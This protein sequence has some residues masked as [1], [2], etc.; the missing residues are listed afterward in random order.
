[1]DSDKSL[2]DVDLDT[3]CFYPFSQLLLQPTG[4]IG[5][6]ATASAERGRE[7]LDIRIRNAVR[8]IQ[9]RMATR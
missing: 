5:D 2:K 6:P 8:Q 3:M 1:M 9:A 7:L 4:V